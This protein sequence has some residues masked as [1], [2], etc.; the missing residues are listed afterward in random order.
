MN[1]FGMEAYPNPTSGLLN[2][3]FTAVKTEN[4]RMVLVD[5]MGRIIKDESFAAEE[6]LNQMKWDMS[7]YL[8]GTYILIAQSENSKAQMRIVVE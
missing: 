6:G 2:V 8:S 5:L 1:E 3:S 7:P 4:Y